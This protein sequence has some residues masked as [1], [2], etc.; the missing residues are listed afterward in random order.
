V[1]RQDDGARHRGGVF[2]VQEAVFAPPEELLIFVRP[3]AVH[4]ASFRSAYVTH[5]RGVWQRDPAAFLGLVE[6][7]SGG[8]DLT[9][10]DDGGDADDAPRRILAAALEQLA[11][12]RRD[13]AR[14]ALR[15]Q[16]VNPP[17]PGAPETRQRARR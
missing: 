16:G 9:L 11:T 12:S 1:A 2:R 15:R 8:A 5:L 7:A 3:G 6:L 13:R 10:V 17:P 14:R 4:P